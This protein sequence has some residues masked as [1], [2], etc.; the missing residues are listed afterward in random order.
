MTTNMISLKSFALSKPPVRSEDGSSVEPTGTGT[1]SKSFT[2]DLR[3][4]LE[5]CLFVQEGLPCPQ[6]YCSLSSACRLTE[7]TH[8][9]CDPP[10]TTISGTSTSHLGNLNKKGGAQPTALFSPSR[11]VILSNTYT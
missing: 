5:E 1:I 11:P 7:L 9:R 3:G 10:L 2:D 6:K 4:S 8:V